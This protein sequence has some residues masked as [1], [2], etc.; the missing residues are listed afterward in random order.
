MKK[1]EFRVSG[2]TVVKYLDFSKKKEMRKKSL[3]KRT[4]SETLA[5][6]I[7][8]KHLLKSDFIVEYWFQF[9]RFD[10]YIP[11]I[12]TAIEIDGEY[13]ETDFQSAYDK[14]TDKYLKS[15]YKIEVIRIKNKD[16]LMHMDSIGKYISTRLVH[17]KTKNI[18]KLQNKTNLS[19][20]T[21]NKKV[22][23][24][25]KSLKEQ[26][27]LTNDQLKYLNGIVFCKNENNKSFSK[28]KEKKVILRKQQMQICH[29]QD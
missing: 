21:F 7:L 12:K 20:K 13:H 15:R 25:I 26:N 29:N 5:E 10:F 11:L 22:K 16:V 4:E 28:T 18:F 6:E 17:A 27:K 3:R 14:E 8:N 19:V 1:I 9:R 24:K 23:N 2:N